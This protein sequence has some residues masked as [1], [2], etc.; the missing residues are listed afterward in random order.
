[1]LALFAI[2]WGY[3]VYFEVQHHGQTPGKMAAGIRVIRSDG[4]P[5]GLREASLRSLL[6]LVD[7]LPTPTYALG[8]LV[9]LRD[10]QSRRIGDM[11]AGTLVIR[12]SSPVGQSRISGA[13]WAA[14]AEKGQANQGLKLPGGTVSAQKIAILE[15]FWERRESL[16]VNRRQ[17]LAEKLMKPLWVALQPDGERPQGSAEKWIGE[18]LKRVSPSETASGA[19]V[20]SN[21]AAEVKQAEWAKLAAK[22][23]SI[24]RRGR[25]GLRAL[26][27][28]ELTDLL[29]EYGALTSDLARARSLGAAPA[30]VE[31]LNRI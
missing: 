21:A 23:A 2:S 17:E 29:N 12:E 5:V 11:V 30:T 22:V 13:I 16:G 15:Q 27:A 18:I 7:G 31:Y 1:M 24:S 26:S 19:S 8:G 25:R 6:S 28:A 14:R 20:L 4:M 3:S 9:S 10:A